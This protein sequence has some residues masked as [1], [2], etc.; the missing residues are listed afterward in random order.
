MSSLKWT[1]AVVNGPSFGLPKRPFQAQHPPPRAS[2]RE[3]HDAHHRNTDLPDAGAVPARECLCDGRQGRSAG[4]RQQPERQPELAL[5]QDRHRCR[6]HRDR[7][8]QRL[9]AR[10][11][12][13]RAGSELASRRRGPDP[14]RAALA[15]DVQRHDGPR[16]DRGGR[17][18]GAER[19]RHGA[20]GH[21]G[22]GAADAGVEPARRQGQGAHPG[23][24]SRQY[25]GGRAQ[26]QGARHQGGQDRRRLRHRRQGRR[27]PPR[28]SATT[29]TSWSICTARPG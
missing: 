4:P 7:R 25:A 11:G 14:Y 22:Q 19:H 2:G 15:E 6:H 23:L 18:R 26:P 10:G 8:V 21:Q 3:D 12:T 9:A 16:H 29:W 27:D 13:R 1:C 28:P 24:R 17:R 20:L 5:P